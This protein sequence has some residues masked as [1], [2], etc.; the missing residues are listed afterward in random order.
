M[1]TFVAGCDTT[2]CGRN[3]AGIV[4]DKFQELERDKQ[5]QK[6]RAQTRATV[7]Q[8]IHVKRLYSLL[9][10]AVRMRRLRKKRQHQRAAASGAES[11][12][13]SQVE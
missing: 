4:C 3:P 8:Q 6:E 10:A 5:E 2:E 1:L 9:E 12:S 13:G 7:E 11:E